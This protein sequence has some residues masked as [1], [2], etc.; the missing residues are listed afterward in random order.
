LKTRSQA[1]FYVE[2]IIKFNPE[3]QKI[4]SFEQLQSAMADIGCIQP[5]WIVV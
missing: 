3:I 5:R 1:A 2:K 4:I